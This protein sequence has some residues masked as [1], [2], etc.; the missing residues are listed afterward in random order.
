MLSSSLHAQAFLLTVAK[1]GNGAGTVAS[2]HSDIYCGSDCSQEYAEGESVILTATADPGSVF[3]GWSGG[4]CTGA[5][6]CLLTMESDVTVTATFSLLGSLSV[7]EG[8]IGT[9]ITITDTG[10]GTK[11]GKVTV[12]EKSCKVLQWA[13]ESITCEVK[14]ALPPGPY[15]VVVQPKETEDAASI[16]YEGAFTMM[17]PEIVSVDPGSAPTQKIEVSG[18]YFGTKMGKVY[19]VDPATGKKKNCKLKEWYMDDPWDE[20]KQYT[21]QRKCKVTSW[22][23]DPA[24][25][26]STLTFVR[27]WKLHAG[28]YGLEVVNKIGSATAL[29]TV[30]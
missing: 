9:Q 15:D 17:A 27:Y 23:M 10:F 25:G 8:T 20:V 16:A 18:I 26:V 24:S 29:F 12:G 4:E 5:G 1:S 30:N 11:K 28:T 14:T 21:V 3:G 19:L 6:D 2:E 13:N 7:N 22:T